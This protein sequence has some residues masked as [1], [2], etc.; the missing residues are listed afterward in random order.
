MQHSPLGCGEGE[1]PA[2]RFSTLRMQNTPPPS[3][4]SPFPALLWPLTEG[5][6][7]RLGWAGPARTQNAPGAAPSRARRWID[8]SRTVSRSIMR[9]LMFGPVS[10]YPEIV[11][12]FR[13]DPARLCEQGLFFGQIRSRLMLIIEASGAQLRRIGFIAIAISVFVFRD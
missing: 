11:D 2:G 7:S 3:R 1:A 6:P 5:I 9:T 13:S 4:R 12:V 10:S 8:R